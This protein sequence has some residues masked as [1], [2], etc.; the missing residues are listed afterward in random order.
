[1]AVRRPLLLS[2]I[3]RNSRMIEATSPF[4]FIIDLTQHCVLQRADMR[5]P[6]SGPARMRSHSDAQIRTAL[7]FAVLTFLSGCA[8]EPAPYVPKAAGSTT[9]Y[10]GTQL[11]T[12]RYRITFTGNASTD[13]QRVEDYLLMRSAQVTLKAGRNWFMFDT[14]TTEAKTTYM[15]TFSSFPG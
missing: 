14:R 7:T 13:R 3:N 2:H 11:T 12:D 5:M 9:G 6:L 10:T 8:N 1:M 15:S 4:R